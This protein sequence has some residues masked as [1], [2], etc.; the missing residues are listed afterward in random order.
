MPKNES[1][2][3]SCIFQG[4]FRVTSGPVWAKSANI[5]RGLALT[6][7]QYINPLKT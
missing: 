4:L 5:Q 2:A 6:L 3:V 1:A 7:Q